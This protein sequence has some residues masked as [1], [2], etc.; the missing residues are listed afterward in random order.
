MRHQSEEGVATVASVSTASA[1]AD[2]A[3]GDMEVDGAL[4]SIGVQRYLGSIK[5]HQQFHLV[6]MQ[7]HEQAIERDDASA[8]TEHAHEAGTQFATAAR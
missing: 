1:A 8:S 3:L 2:L 6:G 4:R 5:Y 7:P